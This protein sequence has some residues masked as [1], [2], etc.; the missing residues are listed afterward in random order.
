MHESFPSK[1]NI[2]DKNYLFLLTCWHSSSKI[3]DV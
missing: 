1:L 2:Y 3:K